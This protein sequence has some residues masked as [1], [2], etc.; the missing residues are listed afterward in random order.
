MLLVHR[1]EL[2]DSLV[3]HDPKAGA[4]FAA[5]WKRMDKYM[6]LQP[7]SPDARM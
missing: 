4:E 3:I 5:W 1:P 2:F 7:P 6:Q